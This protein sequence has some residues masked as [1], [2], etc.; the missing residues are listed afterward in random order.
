MA[1][2]STTSKRSHQL[3]AVF[4]SCLLSILVFAFVYSYVFKSDPQAFAFNADIRF[5]QT[6]SV[7]Q[8]AKSEIA[9]LA[10]EIPSLIDLQHALATR[11][12]FDS[13][14]GIVTF[15]RVEFIFSSNY[16]YQF[17]DDRRKRLDKP[18]S[19]TITSYDVSG[20]RV[21]QRITPFIPILSEKSKIA[22][23]RDYTF[24]FLLEIQQAIQKRESQLASFAS[25]NPDVWSFW[26]FLYFS[27]ITQTT[28]GYGDI[29]PN[30][31]LVRI[32]VMLQLLITSVL[33]IV[34]LN[35]VLQKSKTG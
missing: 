14:T 20:K 7:A 11:T 22:H 13:T 23:Y 35:S 2:D 28:V 5:S 30:R 31:T 1:N 25:P 21:F 26:D 17:S 29:L 4:G 12:S 24:S 15:P 27:T 16:S 9:Q 10:K 34:V 18:H 32:L 33:L 19:M 6:E 3:C 8:S